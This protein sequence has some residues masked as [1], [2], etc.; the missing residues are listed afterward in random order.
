M[1]TDFEFSFPL[2]VTGAPAE[3]SFVC[4]RNAP[5]DV[6]WTSARL[7]FEEGEDA[8]P[9]DFQW[10]R[11]GDFDLVRIRDHADHYVWDDRILC[12]LFRPDYAYLAEI[13]LL[14]MVLGLWLER[15]G[16]PALHASGAVV[17]GH[18]VAFL[19]NKGGGKTTTA[20]ALVAAGY[21][22]LT[23][24]LLAIDQ[25]GVVPL[26][27]PGY[28]QLRLWPEQADHFLGG[29]EDLELVHPEYTKRRV[30]VGEGGFGSFAAEPVPLHR[31]Y[32]PQREA[33][34]GVS[35]ERLRPQQGLIELIRHTFLPREVHRFGWQPQ[36]M[37]A[38]ARLLESVPVCRL[39][40]PDGLDEL[41]QLV[42]AIS[43][44]VANHL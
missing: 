21:P 6:D 37:A 35:V 34:S 27:H 10:Y 2:R 5:V 20:T 17:D 39:R 13:Q 9:A 31:I 23:D 14:G 19:A 32:L 22:L 11:F 24:D 43:H 36:R 15:R 7:V 12:H 25:R 1:E 26:A 28:P 18:A 8:Q 33:R 38:L 29:H 4:S 16:R 41:P 42:A 30:I 44:D 40:Y 3:L